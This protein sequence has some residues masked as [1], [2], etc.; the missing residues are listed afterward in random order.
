MACKYCPTDQ[1]ESHL[2][3]QLFF[4][5]ECNICG[6]YFYSPGNRKKVPG[7][8]DGKLVPEYGKYVEFENGKEWKKWSKARREAR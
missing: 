3:G 6:A 1:V 7:W 4:L 2:R 8:A 5:L